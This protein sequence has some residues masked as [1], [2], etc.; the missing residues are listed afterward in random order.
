[1]LAHAQVDT[2]QSYGEHLNP[3][4]ASKDQQLQADQIHEAVFMM[5]QLINGLKCL[6]A[7][8]VE[9]IPDSLTSFIV[10]REAQAPLG[11]TLNLPSPDDRLSS[12][13]APKTNCYGRLCILQGCVSNPDFYYM[14]NKY[15]SSENFNYHGSKDTA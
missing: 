1:M 15:I 3:T 9:E 13:S 10:L 6:Q 4:E 2:I 7:R 12:L 8:G 11:S 14:G 5:L